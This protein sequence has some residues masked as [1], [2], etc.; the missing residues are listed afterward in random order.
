VSE[1]LSVSVHSFIDSQHSNIT[2]SHYS[3]FFFTSMMPKLTAR[4]QKVID[5]VSSFHCCSLTKN[6]TV[7]SLKTEFKQL[8]N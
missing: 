5:A 1:Q 7:K 8:Q 3:S 6:E 4:I 2:M